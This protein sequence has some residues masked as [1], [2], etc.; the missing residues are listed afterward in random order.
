MKNAFIITIFLLFMVIKGSAQ[1]WHQDPVDGKPLPKQTSKALFYNGAAFLVAS[2]LVTQTTKPIVFD[3][4]T[5]LE[6]KDLSN[7]FIGVGSYLI[8]RGVYRAIF[9]AKKRHKRV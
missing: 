7:V 2:Q 5:R 6:T 1:V 4:N 9:P 8:V 3:S